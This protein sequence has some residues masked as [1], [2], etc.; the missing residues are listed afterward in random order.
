[1][2]AQLMQI[3]DPVG[4][5]TW[6]INVYAGELDVRPP[7]APTAWPG[8]RTAKARRPP[9]VGRVDGRH[10]PVNRIVLEAG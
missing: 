10:V 5:D 1:M 6:R 8:Q 7:G 9:T 2:N 3:R 4:E